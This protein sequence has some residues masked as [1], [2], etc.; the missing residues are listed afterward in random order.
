MF[1][2]DGEGNEYPSL[3]LAIAAARQLSLA[4]Q[5]SITILKDGKFCRLLRY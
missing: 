1:T 2:I 3:H 4:Y 5:R